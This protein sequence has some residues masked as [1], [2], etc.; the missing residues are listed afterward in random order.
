[1]YDG[2]LFAPL[3]RPCV[4]GYDKRGDCNEIFGQN[5]EGKTELI[6]KS[7]KFVSLLYEMAYL[8]QTDHFPPF[9]TSHFVI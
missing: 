6:V 9:S 1:M 3:N 7:D 5:V 4:G 8:T 2:C